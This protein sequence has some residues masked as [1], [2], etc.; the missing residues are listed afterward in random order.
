MT[1]KEWKEKV[2]K[3]MGRELKFP[4]SKFISKSYF[5][6]NWLTISLKAQ[7][8]PSKINKKETHTKIYHYATVE[9]PKDQ[10]KIFKAARVKKTYLQNRNGLA[11][12][13]L[14]TNRNENW[15]VY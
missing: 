11:V 2:T 9:N 12:G 3:R 1:V 15:T 6:S 5:N 14:Y 4:S 10:E 7:Q 13:F 8:I